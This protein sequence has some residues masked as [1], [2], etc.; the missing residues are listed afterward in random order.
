MSRQLI[1]KLLG[2]FIGISGLLLYP[3]MV[4]ADWGSERNRY[5]IGGELK[6]GAPMSDVDNA[7][8]FYTDSIET[9]YD[10][11]YKQDFDKNYEGMKI[12]YYRVK[13]G[14][15]ENEYYVFCFK[16]KLLVGKTRSEC[17]NVSKDFQTWQQI[18]DELQYSED[19]NRT[20]SVPLKLNLE[21]YA[22]GQFSGFSF[23]DKIFLG[24][25]PLEA[26]PECAVDR[27]S[28]DANAEQSGRPC[29]AT[30]LKDKFVKYFNLPEFGRKA[31]VYAELES[32]KVKRIAYVSNKFDSKDFSRW[33]KEMAEKQFG[34]Q[35][36]FEE[37]QVSDD[38]GKFSIK[39]IRYWKRSGATIY[40][41]SYGHL[42]GKA[43][44][45]MD[46]D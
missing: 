32:G 26:V 43:M 42:S 27:S 37:T 1:H 13:P 39:E 29:A 33:V 8:G 4:Q 38:R 25:S 45:I 6:Y 2:M 18:K 5:Q 30:L 21:P 34:P 23:L 7:M 22:D 3:T 10:R 41:T 44:L 28:L 11:S 46:A 9:Y 19:Y 36:Y 15:N 16:N 12:H 40:L 17:E 31:N 24:K 35:I 14:S 20:R